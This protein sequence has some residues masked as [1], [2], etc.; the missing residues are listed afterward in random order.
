MFN[1]LSSGPQVCAG[2]DLLL[3]IGKAVISTV[4]SRGRYVL[5]EPALDPAQPMPYAFNYFDVRLG[6]RA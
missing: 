5:Q 3:F 4:L 1:H 2:I 6:R